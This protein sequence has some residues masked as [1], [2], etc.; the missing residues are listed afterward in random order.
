MFLSVPT[1]T[2]A[3]LDETLKRVK[4]TTSRTKSAIEAY[5]INVCIGYIFKERQADFGLQSIT[6]V[7]HVILHFLGR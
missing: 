1:M 4:F 6:L 7:I 2:Y 3:V 5:S